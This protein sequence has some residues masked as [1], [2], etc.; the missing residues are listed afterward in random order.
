MKISHRHFALLAGASVVALG[1]AGPAF[2]AATA[3]P[4]I[5]STV[6]PDDES[7][8]ICEIASDHDAVPNSPCSFWDA[9]DDGTSTAMATV[10]SV[11]T[12]QIEQT[13]SGR[14][15]DLVIVNDGDAEL[16]AH[17]TAANIEGGDANAL[18]NVSLGISRR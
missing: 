1:A 5:Q 4:G 9:K 8:V 18:V 7:L 17:A 10:D 13:G 6:P 2:A 12:G 11:P 3:S 16:G 15:V 14:E